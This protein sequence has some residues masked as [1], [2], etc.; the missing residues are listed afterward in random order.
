MSIWKYSGILNDDVKPRRSRAD[1]RTNM[2]K[3]PR[4][5]AIRE[6]IGNQ[7]QELLEQEK[8]QENQAKTKEVW[9]KLVSLYDG[10]SKVKRGKLHTHRR[11]FESLKMDDEEDIASYFLRVVEVVHSLKGLEEKIEES[12]IVQ[13]VL[14]SLPDRF[15]SK[16]SAIEEMKDLDTLKMYELHG[17]LIAYELRKGIPSSKDAAF[18]ASK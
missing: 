13:K 1:Q 17:I 6:A 3:K 18:K 16:V 15:D 2:S 8:L 7:E 9:D 11:H 10:D 4:R 12:T 5:K 14:R